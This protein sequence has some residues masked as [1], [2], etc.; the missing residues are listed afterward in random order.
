MNIAGGGFEV[1]EGGNTGGE[2]GGEV[3]KVTNVAYSRCCSSTAGGRT[4]RGGGVSAKVPQ[5]QWQVGFWIYQFLVE[6]TRTRRGRAGEARA[7]RGP[8]FLLPP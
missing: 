1:R 4:G 8:V 2:G 6:V 5:K 7:E 3:E